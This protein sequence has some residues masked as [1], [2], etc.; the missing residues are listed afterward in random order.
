[1]SEPEELTTGQIRAIFN[2]RIDD[3]RVRGD[4]AQAARLEVVREY[5]LNENFRR[6]LEDFVWVINEAEPRNISRAMEH[7]ENGVRVI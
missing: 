4:E 5:A 3:L 7:V 2:Q 6:W 1:M